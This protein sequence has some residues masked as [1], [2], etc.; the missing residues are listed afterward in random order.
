MKNIYFMLC[1]LELYRTLIISIA[2]MCMNERFKYFIIYSIRM[3]NGIFFTYKYI[4]IYIGKSFETRRDVGA[5][6][7]VW[8]TFT[9][10]IQI[11][12]SNILM[13]LLLLLLLLYRQ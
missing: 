9:Y 2:A 11:T 5:T 7:P 8:H 3:R 4:K 12:K 13:V 1:L 10:N 6:V